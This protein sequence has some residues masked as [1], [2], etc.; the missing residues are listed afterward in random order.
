MTVENAA[1]DASELDRRFGD[2]NEGGT[3][4]PP[5]RRSPTAPSPRAPSPRV[6]ARAS[7]VL[8]F[9]LKRCSS[10]QLSANFAG[11]G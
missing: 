6:S 11:S 8:M 5:P 9:G 7:P 1:D 10:R 4:T 3:P 2:D